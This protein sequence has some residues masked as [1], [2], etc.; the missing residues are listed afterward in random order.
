MGPPRYA[1]YV[2]AVLSAFYNRPVT[3]LFARNFSRQRKKERFSCLHDLSCPIIVGTTRSR[4]L[5]LERVFP[6]FIFLSGWPDPHE[7][8]FLK[9]RPI[10]VLEQIFKL[11]GISSRRAGLHRRPGQLGE[12]VASRLIAILCLLGTNYAN[13]AR[14]Y[15][16]RVF[17]KQL[18]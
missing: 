17:K 15:L 18:E 5:T 4:T 7:G 12:R 8:S 14:S 10:I 3:Q 6:L 16:K 1:T 11:P 9:T 2:W 13:Y